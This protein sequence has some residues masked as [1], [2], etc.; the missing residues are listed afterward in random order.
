MWVYHSLLIRLMGNS[1]YEFCFFSG[2]N[3]CLIRVSK[4]RKHEKSDLITVGLYS[5]TVRERCKER[6]LVYK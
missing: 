6:S 2:K 5:G 1:K 4:I 3:I